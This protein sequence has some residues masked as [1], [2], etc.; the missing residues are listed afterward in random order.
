MKRIVFRLNFIF[1]LFLTFFLFTKLNVGATTIAEEMGFSI[2]KEMPIVKES[3][4]NNYKVKYNKNYWTA[5]NKGVYEC[6]NFC[7][8][9]GIYQY[10]EEKTDTLYI[11]LTS[12]SNTSPLDQKKIG[13]AHV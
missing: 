3:E 11:F 10:Y 8:W 9:Q 5:H 7:T 4:Q 12:F 2:P 6:A 1:I 13:R